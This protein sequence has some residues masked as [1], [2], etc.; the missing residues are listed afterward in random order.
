MRSYRIDFNLT[1]PFPDGRLIGRIGEKNAAQ[2]AITPPA[3]MDDNENITNY[4]AV[5]LTVGG[6][7]ET[8]PYP[9]NEP[10]TVA[11]TDRLSVG[12]SMAI[13]LEGHDDSGNIIIKTPLVYGLTFEASAVRCGCNIA[14]RYP[15]N[16]VLPSHYHNNKTV[17]D[18]LGEA[19]GSL[20]FNGKAIGAQSI[21]TVELSYEKGESDAM[22]DF[23]DVNSF[24][25]FAYES[26]FPEKAEIISVEIKVIENG[27]ESEWIDLRDLIEHEPFTSYSILMH[28]AFRI[29]GFYG[30]CLA[31][32][33]FFDRQP[34]KFHDLIAA[35]LF[36]GA[37][38]T[39]I[40]ES[41]AE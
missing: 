16:T 36:A 20:T 9:K 40:D 23:C 15:Q 37:R 22:V 28:K 21:K 8:D 27:E 7:V 17:L 29:D 14:G 4:V 1:D 31:T 19:D 24:S 18:K 35:G 34:N 2:L 13:Q 5:F 12:Y 32:V 11:V 26:F 10:I 39:Y 25:V 33:N 6:T 38:V 3:E 30:V 41:G